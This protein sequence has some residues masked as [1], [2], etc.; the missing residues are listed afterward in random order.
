[1]ETSSSRDLISQHLII[2]RSVWT[3]EQFQGNKLT[4]R[5]SNVQNWNEINLCWLTWI[6]GY[7]CLSL[8]VGLLLREKITK[9]IISKRSEPWKMIYFF[10]LLGAVTGFRQTV[11]TCADRKD[12]LDKGVFGCTCERN[13]ILFYPKETSG[14]SMWASSSKR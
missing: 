8:M 7:S 10:Y 9:S 11:S 4:L 2:L 12:A 1:M 14:C 6:N 5:E 3:H 13:R